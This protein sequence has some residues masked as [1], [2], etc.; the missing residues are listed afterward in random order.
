MSCVR[1][2]KHGQ[3][4]PYKKTHCC[5]CCCCCCCCSVTAAVV[6]CCC[7]CCFAVVSL[8]LLLHIFCVNH[9]LSLF[10]PPASACL[11][12]LSLLSGFP[13]VPLVNTYRHEKRG[14]EQR[15]RNTKLIKTHSLSL[16]LSLSLSGERGEKRQWQQL[17]MYSDTQQPITTTAPISTMS[18]SSIRRGESARKAWLLSAMATRVCTFATILGTRHQRGHTDVGDGMAVVV[19][20]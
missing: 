3:K 17:Q 11:T 9:A 1:R 19:T 5:C 18:S 15:G 4:F 2:T 12:M 14:R 6:A 20:E 16:S 8:L 13:C 7:C 10:T